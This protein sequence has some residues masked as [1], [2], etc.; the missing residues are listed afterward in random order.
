MIVPLLFDLLSCAFDPRESPVINNEVRKIL[1]SSNLFHSLCSSSSAEKFIGWVLSFI[2]KQLCAKSPGLEQIRSSLLFLSLV[3]EDGMLGASMCSKYFVQSLVNNIDISSTTNKG[4]F[5]IQALKSLLPILPEHTIGNLISKPILRNIIPAQLRCGTQ[6]SFGKP[7]SASHDSSI[8]KDLTVLLQE[9]LRYIDSMAIVHQCFHSNLWAVQ[10]L[11]SESFEDAHRSAADMGERG[12]NSESEPLGGGQ[13][14]HV[15]H[16]ASILFTNVI[17]QSDSFQY[18]E[19]LPVV[20]AFVSQVN[21]AYVS[22]VLGADPH[23]ARDVMLLP[24][25]GAAFLITNEATT[26]FGYQLLELH[27]PSAV[28]FL[29]WVSHVRGTNIQQRSVVSS[30]PVFES[31]YVDDKDRYNGDLHEIIG[32]DCLE[33]R[34]PKLHKEDGTKISAMQDGVAET[35]SLTGSAYDTVLNL[36]QQCVPPFSKEQT[37]HYTSNR[38]LNAQY[39]WQPRMKL[40]TRIKD[41]TSSVVDNVMG[42]VPVITTMSSNLPESMIAVGNNAGEVFIYDLRRHP[43]VLIQKK[44]FGSVDGN[45]PPI[46]QVN[47]FNH[48]GNVLVC[49]GGLHLL[50]AET[51]TVT[52]SL[53]LENASP[54]CST[55]IHKWKGDIFVAFSLLPRGTGAGEILGDSTGEFA[56]ISSSY[57]YTI[58]M[59]CRDSPVN[60]QL[61]SHADPYPKKSH[62][63]PMF[64]ALT[65][66]TS[67]LSREIHTKIRNPPWVGGDTTRFNLTCV[68]AHRDWICTGSISG[69]IHCF[70]RRNGKLLTC[71]K[72]HAKSVQYLDALP[73]HRLLSA[74]GDKTAVLWDMTKTPP[75]KISGVYDIP[76]KEFAMNVTSH[77]FRDDGLVSIPGDSDLLL[78]AIAGRKAVFMPMPQET[79]MD[80]PAARV[81]MSGYDGN[82]IPSSGKLSISSIALLPCRQMILL[83]CEGEI[84]VCL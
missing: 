74:G 19:I 17:R 57:L 21:D 8:I 39:F 40:S 31:L 51:Q 36:I 62:L 67:L 81:V 11:L 52:S 14:D 82:R 60:G 16:E 25:I 66:N 69:H 80:V 9:C 83:G 37:R 43:P 75:Q 65:W 23:S 29:S 48:D 33:M 55:E 34:A 56:A 22:I 76:G 84:H 78:C 18:H 61:L 1:L 47:F 2:T 12:M 15:L 58:D 64:K 70:D 54:R 27:C 41:E 63:D 20:E 71:W 79:S 68:T 4:N 72:G 59:R 46:R 28:E 32:G 73:E 13:S 50:C 45:A 24:G 42:T 30:P 77:K 5:V 49:N 7:N 6:S 53:S 26:V 38:D 3:A 10:L 35:L 44:Q